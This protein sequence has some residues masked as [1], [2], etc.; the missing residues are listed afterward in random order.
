MGRGVSKLQRYIV[1]K[2][3]TVE[4]LHYHTILQEYY[5]WKSHRGRFHKEGRVRQSEPTPGS[6]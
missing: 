4:R 5:G 2:A 6:C 3:A 1:T